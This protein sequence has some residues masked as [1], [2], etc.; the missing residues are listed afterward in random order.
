MATD[1]LSLA[2]AS[3][4]TYAALLV[5]GA[6]AAL[7]G[8]STAASARA[9]LAL[10]LGPHHHARITDAVTIWAD[11]IKVAAVPILF[12]LIGAAQ[13]RRTRQLGDLVVVATLAAN[14]TLCGLAVGAYG[15]GL[16]VYVPHMPFEAAGLALA[17][18]T[19]LRA[20]KVP[21][22]TGAMLGV[23]AAATGTALAI[24]GLLETYAAPHI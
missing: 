22:P 2:R 11:N 15:P 14:A 6:F 17:A 23:H 19:W 12:V 3:A 20:R 10:R 21:R 8:M 7:I 5:M 18:A 24:A 13:H 4:L 1:Q 9:V 16:A